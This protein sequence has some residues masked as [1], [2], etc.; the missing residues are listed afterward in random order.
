V[1]LQAGGSWMGI[2][3][4]GEV[5]MLTNITSPTIAT[6]VL[7]RGDLVKNFLTR[8]R[9]ESMDAFVQ[10]YVGTER[11]YGR[12]N[13]LL[14]TPSY[15][16]SPPPSSSSSSSQNP[17]Y[18]SALLTN[19]GT[20]GQIVSV[21][22]MCSGSSPTDSDSERVGAISNADGLGTGEEDWPKVEMG[23]GI[24]EGILDEEEMKEGG[25]EERLIEKLFGMMSWTSP[26]TISRREDLRHT[27]Q[28]RPFGNIGGTYGTRLCTVLLVRDDGGVRWVERDVF[29]LSNEGV[30]EEAEGKGEGGKREFE[31]QIRGSTA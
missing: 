3:L 19:N 21:P 7:S 9:G 24:L 11:K 18:T 17:R 22:S 8:P 30:V 13:L 12:F 29:R 27:I 20:K 31:F 15:S 23:K 25:D 5:A 6:D 1:D 28:V 10:E 26:Q 16:S 14:L 2:N 4:F